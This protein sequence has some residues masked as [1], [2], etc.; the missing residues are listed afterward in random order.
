MRMT[1]MVAEIYDAL[2][3]AG[4]PDDKARKAAEAIAQ[5]ETRMLDLGGRKDRL[6]GKIDRITWM[7]G[8]NISLSLPILGKM[9]MTFH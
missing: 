6:D 4:S 3:A 8:A 5:V 7:L 9:L 1:T 2:M